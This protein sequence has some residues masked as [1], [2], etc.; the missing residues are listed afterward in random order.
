M[1]EIRRAYRIWL[2]GDA[3]GEPFPQTL[4]GVRS[5]GDHPEHHVHRASGV[6]GVVVGTAAKLGRTPIPVRGVAPEQAG[7]GRVVG[8]TDDDVEVPDA[9]LAA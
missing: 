8:E 6:R 7:Q 1:R 2:L 4:D 9:A 5:V 3:F